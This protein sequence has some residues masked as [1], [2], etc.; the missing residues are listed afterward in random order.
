MISDD[1]IKNDKKE[2]QP[3]QKKTKAEKTKGRPQNR[4]EIIRFLQLH[5]KCKQEG[6]GSK[7]V[8]GH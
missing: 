4:S 2:H 1:L 3:H 8:G 5:K 6:E 7:Y